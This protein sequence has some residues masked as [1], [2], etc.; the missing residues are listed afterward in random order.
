MTG[1][2]RFWRTIMTDDNNDPD[3]FMRR[4]AEDERI[5]KTLSA[6]VHDGNK[7]TLLD[8]LAAQGITAVIVTF[9][10]SGDSGQVENIEVQGHVID[11]PATQVELA[12]AS[13]RSTDIRRETLSLTDA[14]EALVYELLRQT[15]EGWENNEG[16]YGE[17]T[18]N[19]AK[20]SITLD[21]NERYEDSK[22]TQH[23]F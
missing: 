4:Y 13:W 17:F 22:Y 10:G 14:V 6:F 1:L 19:V 18:F 15:H 12:F 8:A 11:L 5:Y 3:D 2:F 23:L 20:R 21:Y 7:T 9:D 16:A